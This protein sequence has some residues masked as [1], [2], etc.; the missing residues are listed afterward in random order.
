[1]SPSCFWFFSVGVLPGFTPRKVFAN[2]PGWK[3]GPWKLAD[4]G[5][6]PD[7]A[8]GDKERGELVATFEVETTGSL[9]SGESRE[10]WVAAAA[11]GYLDL[12]VPAWFLPRALGLAKEWGVA[13]HDIWSYSVDGGHAKLKRVTNSRDSFLE[14]PSEEEGEVML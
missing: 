5:I 14:D 4:G 10:R 2:H 9:N 11:A 12:V 1:M 7:V 3:G 13:P 8:V 6:C